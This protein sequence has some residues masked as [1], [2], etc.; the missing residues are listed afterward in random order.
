MI[1]TSLPNKPM[2]CGRRSELTRLSLKA[3]QF[4]VVGLGEAGSVGKGDLRQLPPFDEIVEAHGALGTKLP[5]SYVGSSAT[6]RRRT[7]RI[8]IPVRKTAIGRRSRFIWAA[9]RRI[10]RN[11]FC[12]AI[13]AA[14]M[15][16]L[17]RL[18]VD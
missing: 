11:R 12:R 13:A 3:A 10:E 2:I 8:A 9:R 14:P 6:Q 16:G 4:G 5:S 1:S 18:S 15:N 7:R 17:S